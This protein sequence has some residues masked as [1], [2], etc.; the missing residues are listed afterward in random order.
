MKKPL[1]SLVRLRPT[2]F[3]G[4]LPVIMCLLGLS[5]PP[6][7]A[8]VYCNVTDVQAKAMPNGVQVTIVA[9]GIL[10]WEAHRDMRDRWREKVTRIGLR[11]EN[12]RSKIDRNFIPVNQTPLSHVEVSVPQDA[13][14]GIGLDVIATLTEPS[15]FDVDL[16]RDKQALIITVN[17]E[18]TIERVGTGDRVGVSEVN[19]RSQCTVTYAD[20]MLSVRAVNA[21]IH[22]VMGAIARESGVEIAVDDE[23][24]V[25]VERVSLSLPE[26]P[27]DAVIR[28]IAGAY[29]LALEKVGDVYMISAG[30]P[31]SLATYSRSG[32]RSFPMRYLQ[33]Q[34]A[35]GLLPTFLYS[36]LHVNEEQ[37]A[38]VVTAPRQMLDKI[39]TDL[40]KTDVAPPQIMIEA[41]AVEM[42]ATRGL[43]LGLAWRYRGMTDDVAGDSTTGDLSYRELGPEDFAVGG[44]YY[45]ATVPTREL[46]VA[47]KAL[48]EE[49]KA[50]IKACPQMA[51]VNGERA[52]IFIGAQRFVLVSFLQY[53]Q[54]QERILSV[55]V[56]VRL[57]VVPWTGGNNE[58]TTDIEA[59]VSNIV[60]IDPESGIPRLS[61]RTAQTTVR[62][63]DGETIVIGGLILNQETIRRRKIPLLGD[64]PVIGGLFQSRTEASTK[65]ELVIFITPHLLK[66]GHLP[67]AKENEVKKR[68]LG[69]QLGQ[70]E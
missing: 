22:R 43:D 58:I 57:K 3:L 42:T 65:T 6:S 5:P 45:Q 48:L 36:Y 69:E 61:S 32:T 7:W 59:E 37:N 1:L 17:S 49:G 30:L 67:E 33:A 25:Y 66:D 54:Q 35:S 20:E 62:V 24:G 19:E 46:S 50:E 2:A 47:V 21:D 70:P 12:A 56:G 13:E 64:I 26:M 10:E 68:M 39:G 34:N 9:D 41:V 18:R 23:I 55:P 15:T 44:E 28:A 29:G 4:T 11:L 27:V 40:G 16:S 8:L 51:A 31:A 63:R 52:E 53:G 14:E 60:S 38:V